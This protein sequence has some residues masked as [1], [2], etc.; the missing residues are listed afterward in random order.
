MRLN[1]SF[2]ASRSTGLNPA[3]TLRPVL[4]G[5]PLDSNLA[6]LGLT[7]AGCR[8]HDHKFDALSAGDYYRLQAFFGRSRYVDVDFASDEEKAA[9]KKP[10]R[11]D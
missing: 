1:S 9:R 10:R 8:C 3:T 5:A 7:F 11:D 6:F 2:S 4:G